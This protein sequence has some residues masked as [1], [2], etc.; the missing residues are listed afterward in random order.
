MCGLAGVWRRDSPIG[1]ADLSDVAAMMQAIV[2]R[3][4][5]D[6]GTWNDGRL[7]L[8][9]QRLTIIDLSRDARQPMHTR[10][11]QGVLVFNGEVYNYKALREMLRDEGVDF[12]SASD[13]EVVLH[14]MHHWGPQKAVPLFNGM[15]AIAYFDRRTS[16]LWLARDRLGIKPMSVAETGDRIIFAS[17][18]KAIIRCGD[19]QRVIDEREITLRLA[20]QYRDSGH[21]LFR[22]IDRLPPGGL[23]RIS[24]EG[25]DKAIFWHVLDALDA[26]RLIGDQP[27]D[28]SQIATLEKMVKDSVGLHCVADT[29]LAT[30][31]SSGVDSGLITAF[32]KQF[33]ED[34]PA[35]VVDPRIGKSEAHDAELTARMVGVEM[36]RVPLEKHQFLDLWPRM[37]WHLESDGWHPSRMALLALA[38]QCHGDGVK[39]LLTGEGADELF[40]GYEH[41]LVRESQWRAQ[42]GARRLFRTPRRLA[43]KLRVGR[44]DPFSSARGTPVLSHRESV[45][46]SLSPELN[47]LPT[48][49]FDHLEMVT[50][51]T[52]RAFLA[53]CLFDLYSHLQD[54]L[55]RHDRISMAA[56]VE[57]RVPFIE[58]QLIDFAIHLPYRF[59]RRWGTSK[60]LL[61]KV[62]SRH[63]PRGNVYAK[64]NG[65]SLSD[66][67]SVGAEGLLEGGLLRDAMRWPSAAMADML[68]LCARDETS[69]LRLVG[70]ELFLRLYMAGE[71][72]DNL[73]AKLHALGADAKQRVAAR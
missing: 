35:Y 26:T 67:F 48:R 4:P 7:A 47:F 59:K 31:C 6:S 8:G 19:F 17:E 12:R 58:N 63:I 5:D 18:D 71:S 23:W 46:R 37:V 43:E 28:A 39:V 69:R 61:K 11:G 60:W 42:S 49:L 62:A 20:G 33:R 41:Q 54:L 53:G 29:S 2:H 27:S 51:L 13:T 30:A 10:D 45:L 56:S 52:E 34:T 21:S 44:L 36:R 50:P 3:G 22:G 15:F 70:M 9:H 73:S 64:K 24:D 16:Q 40:G 32:A 65:F 14:A 1:E 66:A 38:Q 55:H 25:I 57:L 68:S 72:A